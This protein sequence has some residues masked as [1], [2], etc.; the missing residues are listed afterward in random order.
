MTGRRLRRAIEAAAASL[1]RSGV[2]SARTDAE[3]LA[4]HLTGI[5]R[6]RLAF[7]DDPDDGFFEAFEAAVTRRGYRVPLQ[8]ITGVAAFGPLSL[9]VGPGVFIPRPETEAI[10]EWAAGRN[11]PERAV[12]ID[13]CTGSGALAAALCRC[14]PDARIIAVDD[15]PVALGYARRNTAYTVVEVL[16]GDATD[17]QLL[18]ELDGSVDLVV[19]N[20]PYIPL[21]AELEPEVSEHDPAHALF[22]GPD[23]M[24]VIRPIVAR[25]ARWLRGGGL[26]A[27]EHDDTTAEL[28]VETMCATADFDDVRSHTDLAGRPRFVTARKE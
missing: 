25:A 24:A 1:A 15:D 8:H 14:Y 26:L 19:S 11:L 13:V 17:P 10:L 28:T 7:A 20:P 9:Q 4:A 16:G 12:I 6:G 2:D 27:V 23:G 5:D 21:G 18:S 3:L 22:G